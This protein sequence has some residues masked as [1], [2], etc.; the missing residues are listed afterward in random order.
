MSGE[1]GSHHDRGKGGGRQE[2]LAATGSPSVLG[3]RGYFFHF[4]AGLK[5]SYSTSESKNVKA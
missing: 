2:R 4:S 1:V 3:S 5:C